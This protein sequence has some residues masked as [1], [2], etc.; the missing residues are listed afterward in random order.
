M[1]TLLVVTA[2]IEAGAGLA[3][4]LMPSLAA[5]L[6]LGSPLAAPSATV[7]GRLAGA[8]LFTLGLACW[9]GRGE[10]VSRAA[11][12]LVGAMMFY[13]AAAVVLLGYAKIGLAL[14]GALLWPAILLHAAMA[15]WCLACIRNRWT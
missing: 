13:N 11:K 10:G 5:S 6:L 2:A 4:S 15:V 7:V 3:L 8:A 1:N 9:Q 12:T 14:A